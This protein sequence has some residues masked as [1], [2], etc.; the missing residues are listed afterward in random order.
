MG[1]SDN[2]TFP[3]QIFNHFKMYI[4]IFSEF[5]FGVPVVTVVVEGGLDALKAV[6]ESVKYGIPSVVVDGTRRAADILAFAHNNCECERQVKIRVF[7]S[8]RRPI[9]CF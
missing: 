9:Q 2:L 1:E 6:K 7:Q 3:V 8:Q 5:G 4:Y